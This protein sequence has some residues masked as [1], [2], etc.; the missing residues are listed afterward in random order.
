[1][2]P[3]NGGTVRRKDSGIESGSHQ[4]HLVGLLELGIREEMGLVE[5]RGQL[6][7]GE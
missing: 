4:T 3:E 2:K 6:G 7:G 5:K 1:V